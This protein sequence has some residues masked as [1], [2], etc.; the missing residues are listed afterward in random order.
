MM[1]AIAGAGIRRH[2]KGS[3][4]VQLKRYGY[5][6]PLVC[7]IEGKPILQAEIETAVI[8]PFARREALR[9]AAALL[10]SYGITV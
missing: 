7:S 3:T 10:R 8:V 5:R 1:V 6:H 2:P 9:R 4:F